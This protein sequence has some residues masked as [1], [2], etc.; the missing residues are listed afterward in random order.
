[1][2]WGIHDLVLSNAFNAKVR[3][4]Y[5]NGLLYGKLRNTGDTVAMGE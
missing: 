5:S 3:K 2:D 1:M 4:N